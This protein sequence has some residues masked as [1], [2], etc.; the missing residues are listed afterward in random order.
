M[1][2]FALL[3]ATAAFISTPMFA[4]EREVDSHEHGHAELSGV[5]D[6]QAGLI[7]LHI[8]AESIVGFETVPETDAQK[9]A[10]EKAVETLTMNLKSLTSCTEVESEAELE[11]E[12]DHAEFHAEIE[13]ECAT[14]PESIDFSSLFASFPNIEE[15]EAELIVSG[16]AV[17]GEI[18][19]DAP[20]I[21]LK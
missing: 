11:I 21:A 14:M 7:E 2:K 5:F 12:G 19:A 4:E 1:N 6:G 15:I 13:L 9:A 20:T 18:E 8:P 17:T 10:V 16:N 3:F